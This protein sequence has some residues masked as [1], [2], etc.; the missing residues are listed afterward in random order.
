MAKSLQ[1]KQ[2]MVNWLELMRV[3]M[4][5]M[6]RGLSKDS[7]GLQTLASLRPARAGGGGGG[8]CT[9]GSGEEGRRGA[10]VVGAANLGS[11]EH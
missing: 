5:H 10:E 2:Y 9:Q 4:Q 11:E 8:W 7:A 3:R 6:T 1:S